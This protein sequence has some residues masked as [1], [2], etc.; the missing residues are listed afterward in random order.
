MKDIILKIKDNDGIEFTTVGRLYTKGTTTLI[1]YEETDLSGLEGCTTSLTITPN[2]VRMKRSGGAIE[3]S[4]EMVFE[5]GRRVKGLYATPYGNIG[6]EIVT[7]SISGNDPA[8]V[9]PGRLSIDYSLSLKGLFDGRKTLD[10][11]V[12]RSGD[13]VLAADS[14]EEA[15][16]PM[17]SPR[18]IERMMRR[19]AKDMARSSDFSENPVPERNKHVQ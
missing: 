1:Q 10:I 14:T 2:R 13:E 7:N 4:T 17:P 11:E 6:M 19:L 3:G 5:K 16:P 8:F 12:L 15:A 9:D 18:E